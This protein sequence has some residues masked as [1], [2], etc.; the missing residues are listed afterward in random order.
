MAGELIPTSVDPVTEDADF[1]KRF[2]QFRRERQDELRPDD[3]IRPDA[4]E[5]AHM[6]R[7]NPFH[8]EERFEVSHGG[9]VLGWLQGFALTPKS[10]EYESNK[11]I[12]EADIYVRAEMRR[13]GIGTSMLPVVLR[14]MDRRG[15]TK[16]DF[17]V[18]QESGHKF[19][20]WL[21]AE[22]KLSSIESRLK[23]SELDWPELERW[24]A[25]GARRSPQTR[26]DI[27]DGHMPEE[28]W[29]EFAPQLSAMLNTIPF[30]QLDRGEIVVTPETIRDFNE[31]L[32]MS[33]EVQHT[34]LT[35]EPD[36]TMS[37]ITD[38][39]WA[40]YRPTIIHQRFTG[41]QP[42]ARGRGLGKWVKAAMLLHVR[43]LYPDT[44]WIVTD[45]AGSNAPMLAINRAIGFKPYRNGSEYQITREQL[46]E[47]LKGLGI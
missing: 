28:R 13:R 9:R 36:G 35:Q 47:R 1:W 7:V 5:E 6:K 19:M 8:V 21:G 23:F 32:D 14:Q 39:V 30:E 43:E 3:P 34:V 41:V 33:G 40:P 24:V 38:V 10:P 31:R 15:A 22:A 27:I 42:A 25:D 46:A 45:N 2:H 20:R 44:Q 16:L 11:H 29:A 18:E 4:D 12:Y 17:W 37:G 26:V